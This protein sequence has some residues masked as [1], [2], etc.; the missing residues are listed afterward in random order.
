MRSGILIFIYICLMLAACESAQLATV[1]PSPQPIQIMIPPFLTPITNGVHACAEENDQIA[2]LLNTSS[3][4]QQDIGAE[5]LSIWWGENHDLGSYAIPI[6]QDELNIIIHPDNPNNMLS[7]EQIR[8]IF[9]G[10]VENWSNISDYQT[11]IEIWIYPEGNDLDQIFHT[12]LFAGSRFSTLA[13]IAPTSESMVTAIANNK[14]AI[15]F[16]LQ[17]WL[18]DNVTRVQIKTD[19]ELDLQKPILAITTSEPQEGL[20]TL[21]A[22]LQSG[23]GQS[24]LL[25][26]YSPYK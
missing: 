25:Q 9:S 1:P 4:S 19:T 22:C 5:N 16:A 24:S 6:A 21:M 14:G 11:P 3:S 2:I 8:A 18:E 13:H 10:Q 15:G 12:E 23:V 20:R 17:S 7:L 26:Y